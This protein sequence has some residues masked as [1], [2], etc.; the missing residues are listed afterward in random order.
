[1]MPNYLR[2]RYGY[3]VTY[4]N[5]AIIL[6]YAGFTFSGVIATGG[7]PRG[8]GFSPQERSEKNDHRPVKKKFKTSQ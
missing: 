6:S 2:A 5:V 4:K 3:A 8:G 1:M 7:C